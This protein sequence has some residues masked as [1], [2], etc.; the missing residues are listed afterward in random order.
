[1]ASNSE[2]SRR[3]FLEIGVKSSL[4][5]LM[6]KNIHGTS[7][8][9]RAVETSI[10]PKSV[11]I[12][13][14][15]TPLSLVKGAI[16]ALGGMDK[17]V[18]QG[19]SVLIKPNASFNKNPE[20][21]T[22]TNPEVASAVIN[23]CYQEGASEVFLADHVIQ[24]PADRTIQ[25]NGLKDA[26]EKSGA[27]FVL[28]KSLT[29][30]ENI[31]VER[32]KVLREVDVASLYFDCDVLINLPILKHHSATGSTIG[33]KNLMG[34]I[35]DR[36]TIHRGGLEECIADLSLVIKPDITIVDATRALMSNGPDGPGNV[37]EIG[38][39]IAGTDPVAVDVTAL[40]LGKSLGYE[41]FSLNGVRN[42]YVNIGAELGIGDGNPESVASKTIV[43]DVGEEQIDT[44][45]GPAEEEEPSR[46]VIPDWLP[47]ASI[48]AASV[49]AGIAG[50]YYSKRR[51]RIAREGRT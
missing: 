45:I 23:L 24:T 51:E 17:F 18:G 10:D 33:M 4:L 38:Q 21:A 34:L 27:E 13:H 46:I 15:G 32:S 6:V 2:I 29:D 44:H 26:A 16:D 37:V 11:V 12:T 30:F 36:S 31:K 49:A 3:R 1:M 42:R 8:F 5:A 50:M 20:Q 9:L 40:S 28:L 35:W 7:R 25:T 43:L 47:F 19:D 39:V 48:S 22:T 41:D 14:N